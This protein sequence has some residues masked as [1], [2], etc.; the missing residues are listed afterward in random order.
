PELVGE[1]L[2]ARLFASRRNSLLDRTLQGIRARQVHQLVPPGASLLDVGCGR[3]AWLLRHLEADLS[4]AYGIDADCADYSSGNLRLLRFAIDRQLPFPDK[5]FDCVTMLAVV[6]HLEFPHDVLREVSRVLKPGG[7]LLITT[8]TP[9]A[10]P[11]LEF[12]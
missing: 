11:L 12:L 4:E 7:V 2:G 8:P 3:E 10:R 5:R 1:E 6:E 9:R